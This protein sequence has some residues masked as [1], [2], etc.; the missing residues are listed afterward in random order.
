M[1]LNDKL[2]LKQISTVLI[3]DILTKILGFCVL[4]F[5]LT[6][7]P[8]SEFGEFGF[9]FTSVITSSTVMAL[10]FYT[11]IIKDLSKNIN[12]E[13]KIKKNSTLTISVI[14]IN[15]VILSIIFFLDVKYHFLTDFFNITIYNI[16]KLLCIAII[17]FVNVLSLFQYSLLITRK[18]SIEIC[19]F[20]LIKFF[21]VN[22]F[23]LYFLVYF[24]SFY[25]TV[26]LRLLGI[27]IG[28]II[29]LPIIFFIIR[30][31]YIIFYFDYI[32][33]KDCFLKSIPL[34]ISTILS[35]GMILID[36]KLL[37]I[38]FGNAVL[39]E[40]NLVY[41]LLLPLAM[42]CKSISAI[43]VPQIF[44]LKIAKKAFKEIKHSIYVTCLL[45]ILTSLGIYILV[46][47]TFYFEIIKD[48]YM[49][50]INLFVAM[51][52]GTIM[53]CLLVYLDTLYLFINKTKYKFYTTILV[54]IVFSILNFLLIPTYSYYGIAISLFIAN[55]T[56][57]IFGYY[58]VQRKI[59]Y[60]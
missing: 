38:H 55:F 14:S 39:A 7:M 45:L 1:I 41:L 46:N 48:E 25:D 32:Y 31:N 19:F 49:N 2:I 13:S 36:R 24:N 43:L 35:L 10:G 15:I 11:L 40:Y 28:E 60:E 9:I 6:L 42:I 37:Q 22:I 50:V 23:S 47:I 17:I 44:S 5:Y 21:V 27:L 26:L 8:K 4:P 3:I 20:L 58:L 33:F 34:I 18:K 12:L 30:T 53:S 56:G 16:E 52:F 54:L 51:S 57:Y 29:I 59:F